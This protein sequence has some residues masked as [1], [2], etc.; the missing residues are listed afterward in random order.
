MHRQTAPGI[1]RTSQTPRLF[2]LSASSYDTD[3]AQMVEEHDLPH[4]YRV[5]RTNADYALV[6]ASL[7]A[8][9]F[10]GRRRGLSGRNRS[11]SAG[12][13]GSTYYGFAA[14]L[15]ER[16]NRSHPGVTVVLR[17]LSER[18][19]LY[20][21]I[22]T[23]VGIDHLNLTATLSDAEMYHIQK[24]AHEGAKPYLAS[25]GRDQFLDAYSY[26]L[27]TKSHSARQEVNQLAHSLTQ[28]DP[29]FAFERL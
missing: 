11:P 10:R 15:S 14:N 13:R 18:F 3:V 26:W 24:D 21:T 25:C 22:L 5:Y 9:P 8:G 7:F 23:H 29:K 28:L 6:S 19:D 4:R 2:V 1:L 12:G 27:K 16:I 20:A 17:K